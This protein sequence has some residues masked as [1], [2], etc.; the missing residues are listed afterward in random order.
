MTRKCRLGV[1]ADGSVEEGWQGL[2]PSRQSDPHRIERDVFSMGS[3]LQ[4]QEI[5]QAKESFG[6]SLNNA[7]EI[8]K[9]GAL[10]SKKMREALARWFAA[11]PPMSRSELAKT[12]NFKLLAKALARRFPARGPG[13][14]KRPVHYSEN[15]LY[16]EICKVLNPVAAEVVPESTWQPP[17]PG[18]R[19]RRP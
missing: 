2:I 1:R 13:S 16:E 15:D 18:L 10:N 3:W 17:P 8:H 4:E 6:A 19:S 14:A 12:A 7:R 5:E 11:L 9:R